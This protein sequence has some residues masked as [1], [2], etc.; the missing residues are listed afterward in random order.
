VV[1]KKEKKEKGKAN[2]AVAWTEGVT[3]KLL[4]DG[5]REQN[6]PPV[7]L[8]DKLATAKEQERDKRDRKRTEQGG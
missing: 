3:S 2:A 1:K 4:E 8:K 7:E 6:K 5:G